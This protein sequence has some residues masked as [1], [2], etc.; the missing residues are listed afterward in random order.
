MLA[1]SSDFTKIAVIMDVKASKLQRLKPPILLTLSHYFV[2][3]KKAQKTHEYAVDENFS[4]S[5]PF[6][7]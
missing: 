7:I 1:L 2:N 3:L 5:H 6:Y 4:N